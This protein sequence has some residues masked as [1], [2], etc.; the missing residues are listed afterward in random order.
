MNSACGCEPGYSG[1]SGGSTCTSE[2]QFANFRMKFKVEKLNRAN[3][4]IFFIR[5]I[6]V[7]L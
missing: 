1:T 3:Q 2:F 6:Y 4:T 5:T 7:N